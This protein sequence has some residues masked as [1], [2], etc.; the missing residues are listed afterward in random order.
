MV[1][2]GITV[3]YWSF[4][5]KKKEHHREATKVG[6]RYYEGK[7]FSVLFSATGEVLQ[8]YLSSSVEHLEIYNKERTE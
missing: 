2:C 5:S 1:K 3:T 6:C 7:Q 4:G 8:V